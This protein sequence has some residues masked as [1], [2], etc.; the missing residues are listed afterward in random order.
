[1]SEW[2]CKCTT[3]AASEDYGTDVEHVEILIQKFDAFLAAI[4]ANEEKLTTI[5]DKAKGL[6]EGGHSGHPNPEKIKEKVGSD[7]IM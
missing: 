1:M 5:R 6:V 4:E 3:A 7:R 2:L